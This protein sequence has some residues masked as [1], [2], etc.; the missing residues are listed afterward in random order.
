MRHLVKGKLFLE[1]LTQLKA[2]A[3]LSTAVVARQQPEHPTGEVWGTGPA[4][5]PKAQ[6]RQRAAAMVPIG[7]NLPASFCPPWLAN[8]HLD[9]SAVHQGCCSK[10]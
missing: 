6:L 7:L 8:H 1:C 10:D 4:R 3:V 2:L 9:W 5:L